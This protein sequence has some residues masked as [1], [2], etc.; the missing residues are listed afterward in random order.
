MKAGLEQRRCP[1]DRQGTE[2]KAMQQLCKKALR[3]EENTPE[4][5]DWQHLRCCANCVYI[6]AGRDRRGFVTSCG[7]T[8]ERILPSDPACR[9]FV[10]IEQSRLLS[11]SLAGSLAFPKL[12]RRADAFDLSQQVEKRGLFY[13]CHFPHLM[14]CGCKLAEQ[15]PD[16][17]ETQ[18]ALLVPGSVV[19]P[20]FVSSNHCEVL[21]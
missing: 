13:F 10:P 16:D 3:F 19:S 8:G 1:A 12:T 18:A 15:R 5:L 11:E 2:G 4:R 20:F 21:P 7:F 17:R 9:D 14:A 6:R